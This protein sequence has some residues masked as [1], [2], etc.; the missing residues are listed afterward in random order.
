MLEKVSSNLMDKTPRYAEGATGVRVRC[1]PEGSGLVI[2]WED[3]GPGIPVEEK[4]R[5]FSR[6]V[7]KNAGLGLFL[8]R[9][10]LGITGISIRETG[11]PGRGA[12]F[13]MTVPEGVY[14]SESGEPEARG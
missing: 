3:D 14:R 8:T 6:G 11:E 1:I 2:T 7:G 5:I 12:R 9:E 10:I 4:E 13:E